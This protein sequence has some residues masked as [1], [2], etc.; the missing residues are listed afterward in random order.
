MVIG[1]YLGESSGKLIS[2]VS[3]LK[4]LHIYEPIPDFFNEI[5]H[6]FKDSPKVSIRNIAISGVS[7]RIVMDLCADSTLARHTGRSTTGH[8][9]TIELVVHS[10]TLG[11]A[12]KDV[13]DVSE[14]SIL[15]NCEGSEYEILESIKAM[16]KKPYSLFFQ[17]HT[18]GEDSY[19]KLYRTRS[20]L[21]Q[22]YIPIVC[23]DW[24]W[25]IWLRKDASPLSAIEIE[26]F[27]YS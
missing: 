4:S 24:A 25:D 10:I 7:G 13:N 22:Y 17:T 16:G 12:L 23:E 15:M 14:T 20:E 2:K 26:R 11:E 18:T 19:E 27:K 1:G 21:A 6:K 3:K 9:E 5:Q 8:L